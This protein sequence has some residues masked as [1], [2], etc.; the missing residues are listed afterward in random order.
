MATF[1]NC[2]INTRPYRLTYPVTLTFLDALTPV[3]SVQALQ[4][5]IRIGGNTHAP[6]SHLLANYRIATT[7][8]NSIDYL[9]IGQYG[10]QAW[11]PIHFRFS[12]ISQAVLEQNTL[13]LPLCKGFPLLG[14]E[15]RRILITRGTNPYITSF[16][17]KGNKCFDRLGLIGFVVIP[18]AKELGKYPL[19]MAVVGRIGGL[20]LTTPVKGKA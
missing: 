14:G 17:K 1:G 9:I 11:T 5:A 8:R 10:T 20:H 4:E 2:K 7:L 16:F 13:L 18:R 12:Q 15:G 3:Y 19:G 6:L